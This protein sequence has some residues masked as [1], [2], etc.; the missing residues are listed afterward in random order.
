[1]PTS[2]ECAQRAIVQLKKG[3]VLNGREE[4]RNFLKDLPA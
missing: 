3:G 1:M 2:S 4:R